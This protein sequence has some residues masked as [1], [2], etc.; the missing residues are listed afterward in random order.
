MTAAAKDIGSLVYDLH[1][2]RIDAGAVPAEMIEL[3]SLGY[4]PAK[5]F[6]RYAV[7]TTHAAWLHRDLPIATWVLAGRP[8]PAIAALV[9]LRPEPLF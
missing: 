9:D 1:V 5:H 8:D 2:S 3:H 7:G 4:W 6:P